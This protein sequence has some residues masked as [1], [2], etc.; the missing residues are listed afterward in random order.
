MSSLKRELIAKVPQHLH[1]EPHFPTILDFVKENAITD[2]HHLHNYLEQKVAI[3]ET[4]L[5][6]NNKGSNSV[7]MK[8]VRDMVIQLEVLRKCLH[9]TKSYLF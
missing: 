7:T 2:K 1:G 4:W 9:L 6:H 5:D 3:T 8:S